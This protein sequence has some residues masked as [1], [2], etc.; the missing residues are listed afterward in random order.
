VNANDEIVALNGCAV[1]AKEFDE[2]ISRLHARAMVDL[3]IFRHGRLRSIRF[4]LTEKPAGVWRL[5]RV[6]N[7]T[8]AQAAA[9]KS[10]LHQAWPGA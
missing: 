6:N 2:H 1:T 10:W 8:E 5:I 7:P 3:S 4:Q 9:Y